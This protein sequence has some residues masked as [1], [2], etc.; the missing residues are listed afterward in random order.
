MPLYNLLEKK[1][2]SLGVSF[3]KGSPKPYYLPF[4]LINKVILKPSLQVNKQFQH[5]KKVAWNSHQISWNSHHY[6]ACLLQN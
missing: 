3:Q 4:F 5:Y 2:T 1:F 6:W